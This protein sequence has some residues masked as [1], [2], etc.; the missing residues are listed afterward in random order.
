[1][2]HALTVAAKGRHQWQP[3]SGLCA[4][5]EHSA[6]EPSCV[7]AGPATH[8]HVIC[9]ELCRPDSSSLSFVTLYQ[10]YFAANNFTVKNECQL[11]V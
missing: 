3:D 4:R 11:Y 5:S 7:A 10:Y 8:V 1:M 6:H 9:Q 2:A